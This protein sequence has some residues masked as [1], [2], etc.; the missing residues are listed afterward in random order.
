MLL[1]LLLRY[2]SKEK[3]IVRRHNT[4]RPRPSLAHRGALSLDGWGGGGGSGRGRSR[5]GALES[6]EALVED[7]RFHIIGFQVRSGSGG[8]V[9]Q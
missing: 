8:A 4:R 6:R 7:L 9:C 3:I 5:G 2:E 1:L